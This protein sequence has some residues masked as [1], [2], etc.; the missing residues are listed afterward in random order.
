MTIRYLSGLPRVTHTAGAG[1]HNPD[2]PPGPAANTTDRVDLAHLTGTTPEL[3]AAAGELAARSIPVVYSPMLGSA[4][5]LKNRQPGFMARWAPGGRAG[6]ELLGVAEKIGGMADRVVAEN[7]FMAEYLTDAARIR[8][9]KIVT[10]PVPAPIMGAPAS[11]GKESGGEGNGNLLVAFCDAL[12]PEWNVLHVIFALEKINANAVIVTAGGDAAAA[13]DGGYA[14]TCRERAALNQNIRWIAGEGGGDREEVPAALGSASIV[15]DPSPDGRSYAVVAAAVSAGIPAVVSR[16]SVC[17]LSMPDRVALFEPS[18][19][20]LLNH[21]VT[22]A[23]NRSTA[24]DGTP[25]D[26]AISRGDVAGR[27]REIYR[28]VAAGGR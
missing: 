12:T 23:F 4:V 8:R 26:P 5:R 25:P 9:E 20:E 1:H 27:F 13:A 2:A 21:A 19:W 17:R 24:A 15:V 3:L 28:E 6:M 18:S 16:R 14:R 7:S 11:G 10:V 22:V